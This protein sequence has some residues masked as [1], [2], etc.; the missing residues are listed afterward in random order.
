MEQR[1]SNT[2]LHVRTRPT[3]PSSPRGLSW[4]IPSNG[5]ASPPAPRSA[6]S[7]HVRSMAARPFAQMDGGAPGTTAPSLNSTS[8]G[9]R[10]AAP[11]TDTTDGVW[12]V[13]GVVRRRLSCVWWRLIAGGLACTEG[14][15][16]SCRGG[17]QR[18]SRWVRAKPARLGWCSAD[19]AWGRSAHGRDTTDEPRTTRRHASG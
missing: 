16:P 6:S 14:G 17:V 15:W 10:T 12:Q 13:Q 8:T 5:R 19:E 4:F 9:R 1:L 3:V 11:V 2:S 18:R 7:A